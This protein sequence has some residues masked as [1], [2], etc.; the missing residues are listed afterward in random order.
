MRVFGL[1]A[2]VAA[3]FAAAA[4]GNGG[5]DDGRVRLVVESADGQRVAEVWAEIAAT[6]EERR[7]G[8]SGRD[9]LDEDAGMLFLFDGVPT[10]TPFWMR[11]TRIPLDIAFLGRDGRIQEI[12][13][14][15]PFDETLI[16]PELPHWYV[17]EVNAGWFEAQGIGVGGRVEIPGELTGEAR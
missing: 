1:L 7:I 13:R 3:L 10:A 2:V 6:N 17:L 8:L 12:R 15:E 4:C 11:D 14:G 9:E 5:E 16:E